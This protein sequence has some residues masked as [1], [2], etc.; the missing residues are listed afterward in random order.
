[1]KM[2][3]INKNSKLLFYSSFLNLIIRIFSIALKSIAIIWLSNSM[4]VSDYS[5][6]GIFNGF[7]NFLIIVIGFDIYK[8]FQRN[9]PTNSFNEYQGKSQIR[10]YFKSYVLV[11]LFAAFF[12]V[13]NKSIEFFWLAIIV[14]SEHFIQ[15]FYR[16]LIF[17][18]RTMQGSLLLLLKSFFFISYVLINVEFLNELISYRDI[19]IFW[20]ISNCII[21]LFIIVKSTKFGVHLNGSKSPSSEM[22]FSFKTTTLLFVSSIVL[23]SIIS[24]DRYL[25]SLNASDD[26]VASYV[27][28]ISICSLFLVVFDSVFL[29]FTVPKIMKA[30]ENDLDILFKRF[31]LNGLTCLMFIFIIAEI[32]LSL[33]FFTDMLKLFTN[34][35]EY[36]LG[37]IIF[38]LFSISSLLE[39]FIIKS[40]LDTNN[41]IISLISGVFFCILYF[42]LSPATIEN[43]LLVLIM[44]FT[45]LLIL[46]SITVVRKI[47][48]F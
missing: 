36:T 7:S 12:C 11:F 45:L 15:E 3:F 32:L 18:K 23:R 47:T 31:F 42:V 46:K 10:I 22:K 35:Y 26:N 4:S 27:L 14:V 16:M 13:L 2:N 8:I 21:V 40:R 28:L 20:S 43:M 1:M 48:W 17:V 29:S 37:V 44:T 9:N 39:V 34:K 41:L 25:F 33:S 24:I 6:Y 5:D 30:S 19:L 38:L